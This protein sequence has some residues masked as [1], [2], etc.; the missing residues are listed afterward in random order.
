MK[1]S[2]RILT[3]YKGHGPGDS[4]LGKQVTCRVGREAQTDKIIGVVG[5]YQFSSLH[6]ETRPLVFV[7][8][9]WWYRDVFIKI[10]PENTASTLLFLK[11]TIM[12]IVPDYHF[13]YQF[14]DAEIDRLYRAEARAGALLK[15]GALIAVFIACLGLFG[16]AAFVV[17]QKTKEI[18]IR[19]VLGAS[20]PRISLMLSKEFV[21]WVL[22]AN[23]IAWPLVYYAAQAWLGDFHYR[24]G[25]SFWIFPAAGLLALLIAFLTVS[26]QAVKAARTNP[27][28]SLRYE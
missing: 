28:E 15:F 14:L 26:V 13:D 2:L 16:L 3:R 7:M 1:I 27:M 24:T 22:L 12:R 19:K 17:E 25:A 11:D 6:Y 20:A 23:I 21:K 5:D 8:A 18:G 4:P 9:P 10:K